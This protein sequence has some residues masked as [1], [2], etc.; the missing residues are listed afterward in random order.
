MQNVGFCLCRPWTEQN[1]GQENGHIECDGAARD[2]VA[3]TGLTL[4]LHV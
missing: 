3:E 1:V 4:H 2:W